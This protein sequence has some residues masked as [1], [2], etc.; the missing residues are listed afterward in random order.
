MGSLR[1]YQR[2]TIVGRQNAALSLHGSGTVCGTFE[3]PAEVD[4]IG[5]PTDAVRRPVEPAREA[6]RVA[7]F[8]EEIGPIDEEGR[9]PR[10]PQPVRVALA[11]DHCGGEVFVGQT[12]VIQ[13]GAQQ[14]R[15]RRRVGTVPH[16]EQFH[17]HDP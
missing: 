12:D 14:L 4:E 3:G 16:D 8:A 6:R 11:D 7:G 5:K 2:Q 9:G 17:V 10:E 13:S 15:G 1:P